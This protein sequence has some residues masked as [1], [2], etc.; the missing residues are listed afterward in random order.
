[1]LH[2]RAQEKLYQPLF[3]K[4]KNVLSATL[5]TDTTTTNAHVHRTTHIMYWGMYVCNVDINMGG[6]QFTSHRAQDAQ[7][8]DSHCLCSHP[9]IAAP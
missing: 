1:M 7:F 6:P 2:T 4:H 5:N 3:D 9:D 8:Q